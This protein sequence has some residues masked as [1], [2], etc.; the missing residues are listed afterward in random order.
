VK[1]LPYEKGAT[2]NDRHRWN[3]E[4]CHEDLCDLVNTL[5]AAPGSGTK[6]VWV[7]MRAWAD[8][9]YHTKIA[10]YYRDH[11]NPAIA[12]EPELSNEVWNYAGAYRAGVFFF[13]ASPVWPAANQGNSYFAYCKR[14]GEMATLWRAAFNESGPLKQTSRCRPIYGLQIAW[15]DPEK[16][17]LIDV[18]ALTG[19]TPTQW[20]STHVWAVAIT[21]YIGNDGASFVRPSDNTVATTCVTPEDV[22]A[23]HKQQ[24]EGNAAHPEWPSGFTM[25]QAA[26]QYAASIG[27]RLVGYEGGPGSLADSVAPRAIQNTAWM[28]PSYQPIIDSMYD[29]MARA[30]M[31]DSM[32]YLVAEGV[33]ANVSGFCMY[34]SITPGVEN[35]LSTAV[36]RNFYRVPPERT[37]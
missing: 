10:T 14:H 27:V 21:F 26:Y 23:N 8:D 1:Y 7:N 37:A 31:T 15:M 32:C 2:P 4:R 9:A 5:A 33:S 3:A 22:V 28:L 25:A 17:A 16:Q 13:A 12:V 30:G 19:E 11:L 24:L 6:V 18:A 29:T 34:T 20:A 35:T 36:H